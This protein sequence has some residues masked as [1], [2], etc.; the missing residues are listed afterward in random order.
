MVPPLTLMDVITAEYVFQ[1]NA[2]LIVRC[3]DFVEGEEIT[4]GSLGTLVG[5][6]IEIIAI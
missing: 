6:G 1:H 4:L 5:C 2:G 3:L